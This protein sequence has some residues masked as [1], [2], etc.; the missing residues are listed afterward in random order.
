MAKPKAKKIAQPQLEQDS[1]LDEPEEGALEAKLEKIAEMLEIAK[2][3]VEALETGAIVETEADA[4]T[5]IED[6]MDAARE[7]LKQGSAES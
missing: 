2:R 1:T 5:N 3:I 4:D 6:A 7:L